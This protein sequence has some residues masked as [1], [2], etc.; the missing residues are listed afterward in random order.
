MAHRQ[1]QTAEDFADIH[2]VGEAKLR[3]LAETFL[4][5]IAEADG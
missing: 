4:S 5:A 3:D 1:P 2:G